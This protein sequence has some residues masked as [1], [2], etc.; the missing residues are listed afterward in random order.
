[1]GGGSRAWQLV[2]EALT[3]PLVGTVS[4]VEAL[5]LLLLLVAVVLVG[6]N[7][8]DIWQEAGRAE[9]TNGVK[10]T[11]A[12]GAWRRVCADTVKVL[13]FV[14]IVGVA[15]HA[16]PNPNPQLRARSAL[17]TILLLVILSAI[18]F[19]QVNDFLTR[20]RAMRELDHLYIRAGLEQA[21]P[22]GRRAN[23]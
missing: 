8:W 2:A 4:A 19:N 10:L 16:P 11:L 12:R 17:T 3:Y 20:R 6:V 23:P 18:T 7:G 5:A 21:H 14:V 22:P 15:A 13:A 1:M 9:R